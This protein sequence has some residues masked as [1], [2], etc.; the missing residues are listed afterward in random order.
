MDYLK[1]MY[2]E[3]TARTEKLN[4]AVRI[5]LAFFVVILGIGVLDPLQRHQAPD[6]RPP[7]GHPG[8]DLPRAGVGAL[9]VDPVAAAAFA[10]ETARA[11][12]ALLLEHDDGR[13]HAPRMKGIRDPVTDAGR[14]LGR[15]L[16]RC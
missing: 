3:E 4:Y 10:E 12:G 9:T 5:Y 13:A 15:R 11:A 16:C 1:F 7:E 8:R 6:E 14:T 2:E